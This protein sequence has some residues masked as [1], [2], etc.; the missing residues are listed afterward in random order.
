M[1]MRKPRR[2]DHSV[3]RVFDSVR[4]HLPPDISCQTHVCSRESLGLWSR[5]WITVEAAFRQADVNHVTGDVHFL[6]TLM[7]RRR[8]V[9]TVHDLVTVDR[10]KGFRRWLFFLFWFRLPIARS[11]IVTVVSSTTRDHL[12]RELG[13]QR[14]DV[15]IVHNPLFD[16][17]RAVPKPF[18]ASRPRILIVGLAANKNFHRMVAALCGIPCEVRVIGQLQEEHLGS[19]AESGLPYSSAFRLS[20]DEMRNEYAKCDM[21]LF[22]STAE[23]FGLPIL[24]AQAV[25]RPVVTSNLSSMPEVAG[26]AAELVDPF[27]VASIRSGVL[28]V[29]EDEHR[30]AELV[31]RGF[32]NVK[33]FSPQATADQYAALYREVAGLTPPAR[34]GQGQP[35]AAGRA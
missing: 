16:G 17:Y 34:G 22:A 5:L 35:G 8:T 32:E 14:A 11:R 25:G 21:L 26:D 10:L 6:A 4:Q 15:R 29:I 13:T 3:E 30:R 1:F 31:A 27:D 19:L 7:R 33:R 24:E 18:D 2:G 28:R 9:L 12:L 23:G 20:D